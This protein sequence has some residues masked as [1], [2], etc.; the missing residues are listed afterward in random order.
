MPSFEPLPTERTALIARIK[1]VEFSPTRFHRGYDER[2]VDDFLDAVVA[3]L[4]SNEI[5]LTPARI[6]AAAFSQPR[7]KGGYNIEDVD[8]F[9]RLLADAV[10][11]LR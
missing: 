4:A 9:R 1:R 5:P 8:E 2:E 6:R 7:F 3:S 11:R 10:E